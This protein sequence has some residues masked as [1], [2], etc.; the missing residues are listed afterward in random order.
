MMRPVMDFIY[1]TGR[2]LS[3]INPLKISHKIG[4]R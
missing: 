2:F 4:I 3:V 1:I